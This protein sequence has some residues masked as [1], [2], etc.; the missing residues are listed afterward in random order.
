LHKA[1]ADEQIQRILDLV[2]QL[3]DQQGLTRTGEYRIT[4]DCGSDQVKKE[5]TGHENSRQPGRRPACQDLDHQMVLSIPSGEY[6]VGTPYPGRNELTGQK[7]LL[8]SFHMEKF[9]VTNGQFEIFIEDT[10]YETTAERLGYGWVYSGRIQK[11]QDRESGLFKSVWRPSYSRKRIEGA[12]WYQPSGP[13]ST[14]F[15]KRRHPVVQV[16]LEDAMAYAAWAKKRLP[17]EL[18][19][20]AAARTQN[21]YRFPWGDR[22]QEGKCNI[23]SSS[24]ADTCPVDRYP[25]AE[26]TY[27]LADL[28]GNVLEWTSD[29]WPS[30]PNGPS[31]NYYH[32]AKGGSWISDSSIRLYSR[33][34][35]ERNFTSNT[36][37]FRLMWDGQA[38]VT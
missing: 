2:T 26:N 30:A 37:G 11:T 14:L 3:S 19:W 21:G 22:W 33:F 27:G 38:G 24:F 13:G 12:F 10:K 20:E 34:S 16:S 17:S 18:E 7:I 6:R 32:I 4:R 15:R 1:E 23:E 9:P 28:L 8:P 36:L 31:K 35:L 29:E 25:E 5:E